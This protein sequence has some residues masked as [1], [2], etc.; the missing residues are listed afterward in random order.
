MGARI[1]LKEKRFGRLIV[2]EAAPSKNS[3]SYWLCKCD[4]G[5]ECVTR[6]SNL[7]SCM[8]ASC[9]CLARE[10]ARALMTKMKTTHGRSGTP[11]YRAWHDMMLRCYNPSSK[12]FKDYGGR[13]IKVCPEWHELERFC[14][15]M[16]P[17]P[18]E[19]SLDRIDNNG[20]YERGNCKWSTKVEQ[21]GNKRNNI[22]VSFNGERMIL[23]KLAIK[24]GL[25]YPRLHWRFARA[26]WSLL[27]AINASRLPA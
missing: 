23:A 24:L 10:R 12:H 11:E 6:T 22:V 27:D 26:N 5:K 21:Q 9:G 25:S 3:H 17:R 18:I 15:D 13:G 8:T 16:G 20:F 14:D 7:Q 1:D 19:L 4:C 2:Q